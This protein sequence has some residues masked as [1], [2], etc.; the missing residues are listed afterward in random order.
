MGQQQFNELE[1]LLQYVKRCKSVLEIGCCEG[2]TSAI[3]AKA[4]GP[5]CLLRIMDIQ[6]HPELAQNMKGISDWHFGKGDS[7]SDA[8]I[9]WAKKWA[10]YDLVF[11]D[12]SHQYED[13]KADFLNY[14]PM[15]KFIAFH[16]INHPDLG[17]KKLWREIKEIAG[18]LATECVVTGHYMGVGILKPTALEYWVRNDIEDKNYR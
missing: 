1:Y 15:G 5:G 9:E 11:I 4:M 2:R 12:G 6:E 17:V 13:V 7:K 3:F 18:F 14:G 10:P 8:A 16:D